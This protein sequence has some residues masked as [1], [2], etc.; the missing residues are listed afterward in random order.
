MRE[1][2]EQEQEQDASSSWKVLS[3]QVN[4]DRC[5][6]AITVSYRFSRERNIRQTDIPALLRLLH[7]QQLSISEYHRGF[8]MLQSVCQKNRYTNVGGEVMDFIFDHVLWDPRIHPP[9][10]ASSS[11]W[12]HDWTDL[13]CAFPWTWVS[14]SDFCMWN[15]LPKAVPHSVWKSWF[16][17][18]QGHDAR[19]DIQERLLCEWTHPSSEDQYLLSMCQRPC[20]TRR[21]RCLVDFVQLDDGAKQTIWKNALQLYQTQRKRKEEEER[22][23]RKQRKRTWD[24]DEQEGESVFSEPSDWEDEDDQAPFPV[25]PPRLPRYLDK[26]RFVLALSSE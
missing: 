9:F 10:W 7:S 20:S 23:Q 16:T 22:K 2:Q 18:L 17:R 26:L 8:I 5:D 24:A 21:L 12:Q 14:F 1:E 6:E 19:T 13:I 25:L 15:R 11:P 4:S 3:I